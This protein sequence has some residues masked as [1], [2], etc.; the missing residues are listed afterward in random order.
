[1]ATLC[2]WASI[3]ER[4][5]ATGGQKGDQTGK[6]VKVG[7]W[8]NFGQTVVLRFKDRTKAHKAATAMKQLC[9]NDN[10][11][12]CQGHRTSLYDELA[13]VSWRPTELKTHCETDCSAMMSPVLKCAGI[14]VSKNIYTG[15]MVD[16]I[17]ATGQFTKL[18]GKK[19]TTTG[20]NL[21]EGDISVK[22]GKHTIMAVEDGCNVK[23]TS[24]T[25][26]ATSNPTAPY[27]TPKTAAF[28]G[29]VN[30]DVLNVR[31]EPDVNASKLKS[32][33]QIKKGTVVG[34]CGSAIAPDGTL[35]YYIYIDGTKGRKYGYVCAKY[36]NMK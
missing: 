14:S 23:S 6:E 35:W 32:Y 9:A 15:N 16:A 21:M 29:V 12:Y 18:I 27:G 13:K 19:Y 5:K 1:M 26:T 10:V 28:V 36:I 8:Y 33:P 3:D 4:G 24:G 2:G 7:N 30:T 25:K 11:G 17:M 31:T 34:V 22:A 20:D